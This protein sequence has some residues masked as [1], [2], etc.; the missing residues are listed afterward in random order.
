MGSRALRFNRFVAV[1]LAVLSPLAA[2]SEAL[3]APRRV[4]VFPFELLDTSLEGQ[5]RGAN[6]ADLARLETLAPRLSKALAASGRYVAVPI[7]AVE[8][9]ARAQNLQSC[10]GCDA[11]LAAEAG[12]D[13]AITGQVQKVSNLILNMTIYVRDVA[14]GRIVDVA[15]ADM[16]GDTDESW[17]RALDRLVR[18]RL[19]SAPSP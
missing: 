6:P 7:G 17:M 15:S 4:A 2:G 19:A 14:D 18:D 11:K 13:Y 12:A 1:A 5:M 3:A 9:R 16:R 10:G 8:G